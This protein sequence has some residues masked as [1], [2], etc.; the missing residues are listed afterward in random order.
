MKNYYN[1]I[2][3]GVL[4]GA[5]KT[6]H[7]Q[8]MRAILNISLPEEKKKQ[9]QER[10]KNSGQSV[11]AYILH[12]VEVEQQIISEAQLLKMAKRAKKDFKSGET[13]EVSS[14]A[15]LMSA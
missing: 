13:Q 9:I 3:A 7:L 8:N 15:E 1:C 10:A 5:P 2:T 6:Y 12:A 4:K 14:L 11:S